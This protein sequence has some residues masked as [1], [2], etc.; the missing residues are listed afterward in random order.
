[1]VI[2][3]Q[4]NIQFVLP[5]FVLWLLSL[6]TWTAP[7]L[8]SKPRVCQCWCYYTRIIKVKDRIWTKTISPSKVNVVPV[9]SSI[10][11]CC[12]LMLVLLLLLLLTC[13]ATVLFANSFAGF[14]CII[15]RREENMSIP[16]WTW[17]QYNKQQ[18]L[19]LGTMLGSC[20]PSLPPLW[21]KIL[22]DKQ[23]LL[24]GHRI[25]KKTHP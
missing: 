7:G 15:D 12:P 19:P 24:K 13:V 2:F 3:K 25:N 8:F 1:M 4:I 10:E 6:L 21:Q 5:M 22:L 16:R 20:F 11:G 9:D 17:I 14:C 23:G 18:K